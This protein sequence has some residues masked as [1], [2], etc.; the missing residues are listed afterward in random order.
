MDGL[1]GEGD[2]EMSDSLSGEIALKHPLQNN[3]TLW[4]DSPTSRT[5]SKSSK[6]WQSGVKA[7]ANFSTVEDFWSV[8][9]NVMEPSRLGQQANY[10]LFK[11]GVMPAWEDDENKQ[12]GKWVIEPLT[13]NNINKAWRDCLVAIIG[14]AFRD[15]DE[16]CGVVVSVRKMQKHRMALW[17]KTANNREAQD[18][19]GKQFRAV[20]TE[21]MDNP[22]KASY[23]THNAALNA[24]AVSSRKNTVPAMYTVG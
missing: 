3:W 1:T 17:T 18:R 7:V 6:A 14:E 11:T 10:H 19:I 20:V 12:G 13:K 16:V 4:Y 22:P 21:D 9:N 8:Y 15:M 23:Q 5:S 24:V 2:G